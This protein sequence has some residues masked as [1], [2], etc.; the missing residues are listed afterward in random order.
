MG[1]MPTVD[2]TWTVVGLPVA[3]GIIMLGL[4][5]GLTIADFRRVAEYPVVVLLALGCQ[6]ILLPALCFGLVVALGLRPE[7]AMGMMLLAASPGG[8]SANLYSHLFGGNVAL[9]VTLTAVNSVLT[10]VTLPL[11]ANLSYAYFVGTQRSVGLQLDKVFQVL[12]IVLVP[13]AAGMLLRGRFPGLAQTLTRPVKI[14]SVVVLVAVITGAI[15]RERDIIVESFA[16]VGIAALLFNLISLATGYGMPR[17][18]GIGKPEAIAAGME[19]GI[20]NA[21]LAITV[22]VSPALLG[23]TAMAVPPAVYGII[24]FFTAT[25]FGFLV[26]RFPRAVGL[27][28]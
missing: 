27:R 21:T 25:A 9:N 2:S 14:L 26:T 7:L 11:V 16:A 10:V 1:T 3:L 17:L 15:V 19:I 28:A 22:A 23:N 6:V 4:G 8:P 24:M 12:A 5:L 18:L 13:V 20:H